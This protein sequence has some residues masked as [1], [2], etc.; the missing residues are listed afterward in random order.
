MTSTTR[1]ISGI[2]WVMATSMPSLRVTVAMPP[3]AHSAQASVGD[4]AFDGG[5]LGVS[6]VP[7]KATTQRGR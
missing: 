5:E 6:D 7:G 2:A 1:L 4:G 3:L